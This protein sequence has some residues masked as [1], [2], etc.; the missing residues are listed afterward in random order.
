M[1]FAGVKELIRKEFIQLFREKKNR[2]LLFVA[3]ILQII[4]FGY[5]VNTDVKDIKVAVYDQSSTRESRMLIQDMAASN[6]FRVLFH[7]GSDN[8]LHELLLKRKAHVAVKINPDF[9]EQIKKGKTANVQIFVDGSMSNIAATRTAYVMS[10]INTFNKKLLKERFARDIKYGRIDARIRTWYNPNLYSS[11]FF[12]PGIVAFLVMLISLLFTSLAIIREKEAGTMEQLIV[13]PVTPVEFIAG[14]TVPYA[15]I[16]LSQI[17]VVIVI[18]LFWFGIPLEGSLIIL[19]TGVFLF[20]MSTLGIGLF[21]SAISSTQ[22]QAMMT[23]FFFILPFFML[24]GLIFPIVNMPHVIQWLTLLN[25]LRYFLVIIRG[26]FL[27]GAGL[28][29]LWPQFVGLSVLGIIVF[30]GA[31]GFFRKRMD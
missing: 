16:S 3:P 26:V 29:V 24:S 15:I 25:P 20:L 5:V 19:F 22:Q 6:T 27:K 21:I 17:I 1:N 4:I 9:S 30:A 23:T 28:G 13:T 7:P 11:Y 10:V 31:M 8:E 14:K 12:V 2:P 18:A